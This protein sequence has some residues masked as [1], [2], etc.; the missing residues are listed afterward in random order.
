MYGKNNLS[1]N[2]LN[3]L[4]KSFLTA[5]AT[6]F[7]FS[8]LLWDHFHGGVPN[9][10][11]LHQAELPAISN[12]WGGLFIPVFTWFLLGRVQ[13]RINTQAKQESKNRLVNKSWIIF[14]CGLTFGVLLALAFEN[15]FQKFLDLIP[16]LLVVLCLVI[17]IFY[18][19]F[20]LGFVL[21]MT[22]TFGAILPTAFILIF[23]CI[24]F[25]VYKFIRPLILKL[26]GMLNKPSN[27]SSKT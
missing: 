18:A 23:S 12:W 25:L 22:Y 20:I 9:H 14:T 16:F 17:P 7:I 19:E 6:L 3:N 4:I 26:I 24:G 5:L 10:N 13:K 2:P 27:K 21:G 15:E 11:I 1:Q 8:L